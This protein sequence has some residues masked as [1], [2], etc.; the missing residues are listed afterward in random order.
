MEDTPHPS[1]SCTNAPLG[2]MENPIRV[3]GVKGEFDYLQRLST[4][5][6]ERFFF[7]RLG[8]TAPA[9][10]KLVDVYELIA[11]DN[12]ERWVVAISL[13]HN[14]A[15]DEAPEGLWLDP[16]SS[17]WR[18]I[19]VN[20]FIKDFP[21]GLCEVWN[22]KEPARALLVESILSQFTPEE[23]RT[24]SFQRFLAPHPCS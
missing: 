19:G 1:A 20:S 15:S 18:S 14:T 9:N 10:E 13:Y 3:N 6:R 16:I 5:E 24:Q 7:H 23:W 4:L 21:M 2:S 17:F 11:H 22:V 8:S 12:S